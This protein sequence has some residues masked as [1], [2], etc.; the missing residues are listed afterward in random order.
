MVRVATWRT[1]LLGRNHASP[2]EIEAMSF[3]SLRY[4]GE[5]A[6]HLLEA[7][8]RAVPPKVG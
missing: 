2:A 7:E 5:I 4:W 8:K 1:Y 3:S 6:E